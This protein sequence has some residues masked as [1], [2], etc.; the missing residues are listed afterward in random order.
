MLVQFRELCLCVSFSFYFKL[1]KPLHSASLSIE[2]QQRVS[3]CFIFARI[4]YLLKVRG[5]NYLSEEFDHENITKQLML[6][7]CTL[8]FVYSAYVSSGSGTIY[9]LS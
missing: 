2:R 8:F 6:L 5:T 1:D 7:T 3:M 9:F 4:C